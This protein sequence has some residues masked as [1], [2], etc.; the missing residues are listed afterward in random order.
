MGI[1]KTLHLIIYLIIT[2]FILG[3]ATDDAIP[4][5]GN[6]DFSFGPPSVE[7][8]YILF[9]RS[10][11]SANGFITGFDEFPEGDIDA[12]SLSTTLA[13]PA[14]SG[15]ISFKSY[16]VNQ[17]KLFSGPGYQ[18]VFLDENK[19]PIAADIIETFGGGSSVVFVDE[20]KGYY[21][22]FNTL[23]IK[24]FNPETFLPT[25]EIDMSAAYVNENNPSNYYNALYVRGNRLYACLYTG[26]V[27]PPFIYDDPNGVTVAVIDTD[28]DTYLG[29]IFKQGT[30]YGGQPFLRFNSNMQAENGDLF[31]P[32]QGSLTFPVG[33]IADAAILKIAEASDEFD[34]NFNFKAQELINESQASTAVNAGFIYVGDGIAYTNVLMEEPATPA[35]FVNLPLMRWVKMNLNDGTAELVQGIPPNSG[36]TAGQAYNYRDKVQLV[37]YNSELGINAIYE[38]DP[39][40]NTAEQ[41]INVTNGGIIY[42]FYEIEEQNENAENNE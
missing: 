31:L 21:V 2:L 12:P 20:T 4:V 16:V 9:T 5:S 13:F 1:N 26:F 40:T 15:G 10:A 7:K 8:D 38:T 24:I 39:Q 34:P 22:D 11:S 36:F 3:C 25:G 19:V 32:T 37:V 42:G 33:E 30:K 27:F 23:N 6:P 14:I 17:Q 41:I 28:T 18:R 35:D 29:N